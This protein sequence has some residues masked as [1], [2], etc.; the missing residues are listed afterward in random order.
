MEGFDTARLVWPD[1]SVPRAYRLSRKIYLFRDLETGELL[2]RF[3]GKA[4]PTV[5]FPY[6]H[7]IQPAAADSREQLQ[8]SRLR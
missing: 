5:R 6:Q 8:L 4:V 3:R 7:I 2:T 1:R